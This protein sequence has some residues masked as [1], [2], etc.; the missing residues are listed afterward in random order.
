MHAVTSVAQTLDDADA[1]HEM[2]SRA[3]QVLQLAAA[4]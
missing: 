2:E 1:A 3:L 4:L